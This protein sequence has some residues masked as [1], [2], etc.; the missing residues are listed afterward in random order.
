MI[1]SKHLAQALYQLSKE[2][3]DTER[4]V[5][6]FLEYLEKYK[7][8]ALLGGTLRHLE[9]IQSNQEKFNYLEIVSGLPIDKEIT[10]EIKTKLKVDIHSKTEKK[11]D[12]ALIGGFIA[13]YKGF[14]YDASLK[15]Q[16]YLLRTKLIEN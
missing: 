8:Q 1:S 13:T 4:I 16:L 11:I 14:I 6:A 9:R 7:L 2:T 10:E 15:K 12:G 3:T 5:R